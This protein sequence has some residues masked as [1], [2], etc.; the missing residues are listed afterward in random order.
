ML[1][2]RQSER[3]QA[4]VIDAALGLIAV[5]DDLAIDLVDVVAAME[6]YIVE[7][8]KVGDAMV[9]GIADGRRGY[10]LKDG[11]LVSMGR[12]PLPASRPRVTAT[13]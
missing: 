1:E 8:T 10:T 9:D 11:R 12:G 2:L 5:A 3:H 13:G 7:N 4:M 6:R